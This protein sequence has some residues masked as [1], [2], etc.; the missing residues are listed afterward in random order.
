L[1]NIKNLSFSYPNGREIFNGLDFSLQEGEKVGLIGHNGAGK[2][3]LFH[4]IMGLLRPTSGTI[5]IFGKVRKEEKDFTE[6]RQRIGL[7]FQDSDDQLFSPTVEEDIAFGPLNLG[8]SH[9]EAKTIVRETC[10]RLGLSGFEKR[11]THRLSGGEKR[12]VALATVV[13]MNPECY[14]LDEPFAGLD[15]TTTQRFL[16]YLKA[17]TKTYII[18]THDR[19]LLK[20]TVDTIFI[21]NNGKTEKIDSSRGFL[22]KQEKQFSAIMP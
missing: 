19:E 22:K 17:H 8:K 1:I 4:I 15:E 9:K 2:T 18:I 5:D 12:L 13:A 10:E 7:L 20:Q 6:V 11:I 21:L 14:L 16:E 3:T